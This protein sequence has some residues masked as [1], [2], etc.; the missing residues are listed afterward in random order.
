MSARR[1]ATPR[2]LSDT[3]YQRLAQ[4]R[5]AL[6]QFLHFSDDAARR[7]GL[8]PQQYQALVVVRGFADGRAPTI[9]ELARRLLIEHH[10]AVGLVDRLEAVGLLMRK[11]EA[12]DGRR[13][14]VVLT[15]RA[16]DLLRD[17]VAAHRNELRRLMPL[18]KPLFSQLRPPKSPKARAA[19]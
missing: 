9:G 5:F 17:L 19:G 14:A 2:E 1:S 3:D 16:Q 8:S 7:A 15:E 18:M 6:R 12:G 10:S 13:V 4:F 11:K